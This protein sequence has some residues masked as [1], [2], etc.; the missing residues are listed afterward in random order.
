M[1]ADFRHDRA[2]IALRRTPILKIELNCHDTYRDKNKN[3]T[4]I[5]LAHYIRQRGYDLF[6]DLWPESSLYFGNHG[7]KILEIDRAF[8]YPKFG[9]RT[10]EP[11]LK[12]M[13]TRMLNSRFNETLCSRGNKINGVFFTDVI[14]IKTSVAAAMMSHFH[15]V[16]PSSSSSSTTP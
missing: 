15:V 14:A 3:L 8:G 4:G 16:P 1:C 6:I 12:D 11:L 13:A 2:T 10:H 9:I 7:N 5:Q